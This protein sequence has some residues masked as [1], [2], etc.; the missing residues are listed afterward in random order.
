LPDGPLRRRVLEG[1]GRGAEAVARAELRAWRPPAR[2]AAVPETTAGLLERIRGHA[3]WPLLAAR[4]LELELDGDGSRFWPGFHAAAVDAYEGRIE[5]DDLLDGYRQAVGPKAAS[6]SKVFFAAVRRVRA[7]RDRPRAEAA[8][9][10]PRGGPARGR[11]PSILKPS[12][13]P[14]RPGPAKRSLPSSRG[15]RRA[16]RPSSGEPDHGVPGA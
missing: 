11:R 16:S 9:P 13:D 1:I 10:A 2:L 15:R 6:P 5:P 7:A 4:V 3:S 8:R 14:P 12:P